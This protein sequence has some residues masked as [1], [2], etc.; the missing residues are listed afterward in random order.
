VL[1]LWGR[2]FLAK[3]AGSPLAVWREWADRATEV[4]LDCG[5]FVVEEQPTVAAKA[6]QEFFAG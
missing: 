3:K 6:L 5:H 4:A 2:G 1:V